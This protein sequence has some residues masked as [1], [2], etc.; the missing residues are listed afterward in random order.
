M[1]VNLRNAFIALIFSALV[2]P[3]WAAGEV[4][5][6]KAD[7][8]DRYIVQKGDTLWDISGRFLNEPWLWPEVWQINP[9]IEN[10]HLIYPGDEVLLSYKD[11]RPIIRVRRRGRRGTTRMSP[12]VRAENLAGEAIPTIPFDAI[13]QF[14]A[15]PRVVSEIEFEGAPY[16]LSVGAEA[17]S[18]RPGSKVDVRGLADERTTRY[19]VYRKGAA[20]LDPANDDEVLGFEAVQVADAVVVAYG[21]PVTLV[22][23]NTYREVLVGDRLIEVSDNEVNYRYQP[24]PVAEGVNGQIISVVDGVSQIGQYQT[25]VLNLGARDGLEA[26]HVFAVYQSGGVIEDPLARNPVYH[27]RARQRAAERE[28]V[29]D[30][31]EAF[32]YGIGH[33]VEAVSD[34]IGIEAERFASAFTG[35]RSWAEVVLP[36]QR[37][38]TIMVYRPF[39][40][41]S[42]ALVMQ[43]VR[44]MH[45]LDSVKK[46]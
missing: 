20:Y 2:G 29:H 42:Y 39:E 26:G 12:T 40:R 16:I 5:G 41:V 18:A 32:V 8:P 22:I 19:S 15:R 25:V 36:E 45:L 13:A 38:G 34:Q 3:V 30:T 28:R 21:D 9:H 33:A 6:L 1:I 44:P 31:G 35:S 37:A 24:H 11:G 4:P 7:H 27:E 17:L 10:P 23:T 14:L 43:A 46:P